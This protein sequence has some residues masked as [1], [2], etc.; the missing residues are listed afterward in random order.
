MRIIPQVLRH[1][2]VTNLCR[3]ISIDSMLDNCNLQPTLLHLKRMMLHD[4]QQ[5]AKCIDSIIGE[6]A[7]GKFRFRYM[8]KMEQGYDY[9]PTRVFEEDLAGAKYTRWELMAVCRELKEWLHK[10]PAY[11]YPSEING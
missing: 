6:I 2:I 9:D 8:T 3:T 4:K 5:T 7:S 1:Y 11:R 10:Q